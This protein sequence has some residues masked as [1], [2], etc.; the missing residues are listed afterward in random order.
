MVFVLLGE[1]ATLGSGCKVSEKH[2]LHILREMKCIQG[3]SKTCSWIKTNSK[4]QKL[5]W[6]SCGY[7]CK[8]PI[9]RSVLNSVNETNC[10]SAVVTKLVLLG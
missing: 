6:N 5:P 7:N 10:D 9:R 4:I 2:V 8:L 3:S 1:Y